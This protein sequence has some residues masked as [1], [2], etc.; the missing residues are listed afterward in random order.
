MIEFPDIVDPVAAFV[1]DQ[2]A[3]SGF[4]SIIY[5]AAGIALAFFV[6][7]MVIGFFSPRQEKSVFT[8]EKS[9]IDSDDDDEG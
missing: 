7:D 9:G 3:D 8:N 2:F 6:I 1:T 4:S 5:L